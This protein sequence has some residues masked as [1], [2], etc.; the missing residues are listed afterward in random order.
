MSFG[1]QIGESFGLATFEEIKSD[2]DGKALYHLKTAM[3]L[4]RGYSLEQF[5]AMYMELWDA[6]KLPPWAAYY[7]AY[8][9]VVAIALSPPERTLVADLEKPETI[10]ALMI[11]RNIPSFLIELHIDLLARPEIGSVVFD[12]AEAWCKSSDL[13]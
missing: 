9:G 4:R 1:F 11:E 2:A 12:V 7:L 3:G 10:T 6:G 8:A 5:L 13:N